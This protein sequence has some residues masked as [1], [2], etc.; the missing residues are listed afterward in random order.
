MNY[1]RKYKRIGEKNMEENTNA[2]ENSQEEVKT[3]T[4][5]DVNKIIQAEKAKAKKSVTTEYGF[6]NSDAL[7][8]A[9]DKLKGLEEANKTELEK[10]QEQTK[11]YEAQIAEMQNKLKDNEF[12]NAILKSG[13]KSDYADDV[14]TLVKAQVTEEN[15]LDKVL[16][17]IIGKYPHF[18]T[19]NES[20]KAGV[21]TTVTEEDKVSGVMAAFKKM[22][23]N[24]K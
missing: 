20:V 13:V 14:L 19:V 9:L 15:T 16:E 8:A 2:Q 24:I 10:A 5:E 22:N 18:T 6:E 4:Q 23:P 3:F 17:A 1:E 7:K 11:N 12:T 21:K